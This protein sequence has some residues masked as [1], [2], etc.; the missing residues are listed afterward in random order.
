MIWNNTCN[1]ELEITNYELEISLGHGA[2]CLE[3]GKISNLQSCNL[4]SCNL[5]IKYSPIPHSPIPHSPIPYRFI[6]SFN[7]VKR[8]S[9]TIFCLV[10]GSGIITGF[11]VTT[12][13][14]QG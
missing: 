2:W 14:N 10:L 7:C 13:I 3:P 1:R 5:L 8:G 12:G 4:Q 6:F 9:L 11:L